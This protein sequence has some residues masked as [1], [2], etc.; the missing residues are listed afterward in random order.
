MAKRLTRPAAVPDEN[1]TS[2]P[3]SIQE[4]WELIQTLNQRH[5]EIMAALDG[6]KHAVQLLTEQVTQSIQ[7]IQYLKE[8]VEQGQADQAT[9]DQ[10]EQAVT[11]ATNQLA[12]AGSN[13]GGEQHA[14][15][16][17]D[18][19]QHAQGG[20]QQ[21]S[22]ATTPQ[23]AHRGAAAAPQHQAKTTAPPTGARRIGGT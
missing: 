12:D 13:G 11:D 5:Q 4:A 19:A 16:G 20:S 17:S 3:V 1:E 23:T 6:L 21:P 9:I 7:Q 8:Q 22:P 14:Q 15:G 18:D 10:L 2:Q